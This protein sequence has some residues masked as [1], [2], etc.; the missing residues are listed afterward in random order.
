M[1][2]GSGHLSSYRGAHLPPVY[3][4]VEFRTI[5]ADYPNPFVLN[6]IQIDRIEFFS[7]SGELILPCLPEQKGAYSL[8]FITRNRRIGIG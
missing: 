4:P 3:D 5:S 1:H 7:P 2:P 6:S 8:N